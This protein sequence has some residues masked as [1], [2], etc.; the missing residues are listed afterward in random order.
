MVCLTKT[1]CCKCGKLI[2]RNNFS[3]HNI[4]CSGPR[5]EAE[6]SGKRGG[7]NKGLTKETNSSVKKQVETLANKIASGEYIPKGYPH[8]E[9][10][11]A[12]QSIRA[13]ER[14][15]GGHTSKIMTRYVK[16]ND[17]VVFLQS[18]Y[19]IEFAKLLDAMLV[20]WERPEP[21]NYIGE[22]QKPHRY[23]P[24]FKIGDKFFDTKND[25]LSVIDKPKIDRVMQQNNVVIT[26]VTK[27]MITEKFVASII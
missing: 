2:T 16:K 11:K 21:I 9:E 26:I 6:F 23:Y 4:A 22:D 14:N 15:L 27:D 5:E 24:D 7:W 1:E 12:K 10:F 20:D 3:R 19:E 25:Y 8:S 18:S 17:E 13:K